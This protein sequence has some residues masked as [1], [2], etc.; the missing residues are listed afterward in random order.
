MFK[1]T[2]ATVAVLSF[3]SVI[4][5]PAMAWDQRGAPTIQH[6]GDAVQPDVAV[7]TLRAPAYVLPGQEFEVQA[8]IKNVKDVR[9]FNITLATG[10]TVTALDGGSE[11]E[12]HLFAGIP[13]HQVAN[14]TKAR[15]IGATK[16]GSTVQVEAVDSEHPLGAFLGSFTV[17]AG[18]QLG[19]LAIAFNL[20][21]T[22]LR[23]SNKDAIAYKVAKSHTRVVE[24]LPS[25]P[26]SGRPSS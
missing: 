18:T 8:F 23:D 17:K 1:R 3:V 6:R 19:E 16:D 5:V 25:D 12:N 2:L 13:S 11:D 10:G 9:G 20:D 24:Q 21:K 4:V 14:L 7:F 15:L 26:P 22:F